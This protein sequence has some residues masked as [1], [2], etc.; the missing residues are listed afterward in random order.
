MNQ[1]SPFLWPLG[2]QEFLRGWIPCFSEGPTAP[3]PSRYRPLRRRRSLCKK[4]GAWIRKNIWT[5]LLYQLML[6]N[7]FA[8]AS[9][10]ASR[11]KSIEVRWQ[12]KK[13]TS[14]PVPFNLVLAEIVS[15]DPRTSSSTVRNYIWTH[16][17]WRVT[18]ILGFVLI[19]KTLKKRAGDQKR[20]Q[21]SQG[22][23]QRLPTLAWML[24][25]DCLHRQDHF[26]QRTQDETTTDRAA[27]QRGGCFV[28]WMGRP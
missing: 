25:R 14:R 28:T 16:L 27:R 18:R 9:Q 1:L 20:K 22:L 13:G 3:E 2:S 21:R 10:C 26:S 15:S 6:K 8:K 24:N 23:D 17:I 11:R 5:N 12:K 4:Q 7:D 19:S